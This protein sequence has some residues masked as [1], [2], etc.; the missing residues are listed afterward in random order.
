MNIGIDGSRISTNEMTGVDGYTFNLVKAISS[1]D[2][3]NK[4]IIYFSKVP[5]YFEIGHK[6]VSTRVIPLTRFWTQIR[7]AL[8]CLIRPPDILFV[9]AHTMPVI[10]RPNLKT[11]VTIHDLGA[12]FLA[13]YHQFPQKY[14]LNWATEY[15]ALHASHIIAVSES[16]KKDLVKQFKVDPKRIT[17]VYEA[18]DTNKFSP[19][20]TK[21]IE[22]TKK[23]LGIT[24][25]YLLFVGTIQPRKNLLRL[26]EAF[27]K[28]ENKSLELVLAGKPGWLFE[29]IYEAPKKFKVEGR[30]KFVGYVKDDQ[31]PALYSG[32]EMFVFPSLYEGFGLPIL[33]AMAC[34]TAVLTSKTSSMPEVS[35]GNAVLVN[36]NKINEISSGIES[37]LK[38]KLLYRKLSDSGK[39]WASKFTWEET[40][41]ETIKVFEKVGKENGK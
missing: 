4:Y 19:R 17:V 18:V 33:E 35:G 7:L 29:E 27:S 8:E 34:G 38:D 36:P 20:G 26:I 10:R 1:V 28:L 31:L 30:V 32:A 22:Q 39:K 14:Y 9:P 13:E 21:E 37:L 6:N 2:K 5:K 41:R 12:E 15:V 3:V 11:I 25:K 40:A 24:K 16:T 23:E